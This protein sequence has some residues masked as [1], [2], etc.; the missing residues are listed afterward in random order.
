MRTASTAL[1][2]LLALALA[3]CAL[4]EGPG[5]SPFGRQD[6]ELGLI[7][8]GMAEE[9]ATMPEMRG[10][11]IYVG[12]ENFSGPGWTVVLPRLREELNRAANGYC[13]F[14]ARPGGAHCA[15]FGESRPATG[16][17]SKGFRENRFHLL[18][19]RTRRVVYSHT[20]YV[21]E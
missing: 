16:P 10:A 5:P 7:A 21:E 15:M 8:D 3:A 9:L 17:K 2:T 18:D 19:L 1:A 20:E 12:E 13:R 11:A 14:V 6:D 4:P